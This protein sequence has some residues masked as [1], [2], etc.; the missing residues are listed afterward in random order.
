MNASE[1]QTELVSVIIPAY[2]AER[3]IGATLASVIAQT[4]RRL[5]ILVVDDGS[6]DGTV[7]IVEQHM[8]GDGRVRLIR[9]RNG[10][11]A[12]ARNR[13]IA[14]S[15]GPFIA[16]LD[17][18]DLWHP[19]KLETQLA[20]MRRSP[21][22]GCVTTWCCTID[23]DDT[24][25]WEPADG[26]RCEGYVLPALI[27]EHFAGCASSPLL[28]RQCVL[29]AGGYD[30]SLLRRNAQGCED[31]K[32]LLAVAER[33]EFTVIPRALTGYRQ[34]PDSMSCNLWTMLRSHDMVIDEMRARHPEIPAKVY[35]WS[36]SGICAW[37]A[38]RAAL[39]KDHGDML[40]LLGHSIRSDWCYVLSLGVRLATRYADRGFRSGRAVRAEVPRFFPGDLRA[41]EPPPKG[42]WLATAL[43]RH[44]RGWC[45]RLSAKP[46]KARLS[47]NRAL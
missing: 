29:E 13:G 3:Y 42:P 37:L 43:Q 33:H 38:T 41:P 44:R 22:I 19:E 45:E 27:L 2:N 25:L 21:R 8:A 47:A 26:T 20:A 35:R 23:T 11:V 30:E 28:R 12:N 32:L 40:R 34:V 9:Q 46:D 17:A 24:I 18:D 39:A 5:E 16:P 14:E 6:T 36:R 10:G 31:Y 7:A 4:H 15:R 1:S